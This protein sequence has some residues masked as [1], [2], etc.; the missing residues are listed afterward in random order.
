MPESFVSIHVQYGQC[1]EKRI[2]QVSLLA[3]KFRGFT[4][5]KYENIN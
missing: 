2:K 5:K 3:R 1:Y 4:K